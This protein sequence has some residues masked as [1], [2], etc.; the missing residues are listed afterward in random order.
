MQASIE[1][2]IT[3]SFQNLSADSEYRLRLQATRNAVSLKA[4]VEAINV[5]VR[6]T[7]PKVSK[8]ALGN[9]SQ[10]C[11]QRSVVP[12]NACRQ[13]EAVWPT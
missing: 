3:A 1:R 9:V 4:S 7:T 13:M 8:E 10:R 11:P 5:A 2:Q 6:R 12:W